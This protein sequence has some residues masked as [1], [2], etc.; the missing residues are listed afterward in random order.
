MLL[1]I[2]LSRLPYVTSREGHMAQVLSM[3]RIKRR[4]PLQGIF[5]EVSP[6]HYYFPHN[7]KDQYSHLV[8]HDIMHKV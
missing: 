8:H 7:V 1:N 5:L 2:V 4:T 3:I 6:A